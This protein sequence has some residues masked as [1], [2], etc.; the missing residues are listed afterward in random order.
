MISHTSRRAWR[1]SERKHCLFFPFFLSLYFSRQLDKLVRD[2]TPSWS[3]DATQMGLHS[4]GTMHICYAGSRTWLNLATKISM[5]R[6]FPVY[7]S[8]FTYRRG[9]S[10]PPKSNIILFSKRR[11]EWTGGKDKSKHDEIILSFPD[12]LRCKNVTIFAKWRYR[13][14]RD[15]KTISKHARSVA[16]KIWRHEE[17]FSLSTMSKHKGLNLRIKIRP[18]ITEFFTKLLT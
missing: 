2:E 1:Q 6:D 11:R 4:S 9:T 10:V 15:D 13:F 12:K 5:P 7:T 8:Q 18:A 17:L 3:E 16:R 14:R